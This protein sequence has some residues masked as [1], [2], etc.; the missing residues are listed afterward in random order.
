MK[1]WHC[2]NDLVLNHTTEDFEKFYQC[3]LC[4]KWFEQYKE[5]V[6]INGAVPVRFIEL[7][8]RPQIP[9]TAHGFSA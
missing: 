2:N 1:C 8:A 7:D 6:K 3:E 5:K 9:A 4:D